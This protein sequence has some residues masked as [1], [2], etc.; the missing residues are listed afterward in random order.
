MI[1][2]KILMIA[3]A[4][5]V[6][7]GMAKAADAATSMTYTEDY[8]VI[9]SG[10]LLFVVS[11]E[12]NG[13]TSVTQGIGNLAI[14]HVAIAFRDSLN[15]NQLKVVEAIS[16]GVCVTPI[17]TFM[18]RA[19]PVGGN[20]P[21][22]VVGR[23]ACRD[24]VAVWISNALKYVGRPYDHLFMHDDQ[25]IYCSELVMLSY[26]NKNGKPIFAPIRMSFHD[27]SG[28]VTTF[29]RDYYARRGLRV[30]EGAQGSNPGQL[31]RDGNVRII[32][33]FF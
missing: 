20:R 2:T 24:N 19:T 17:D 16:R 33:R 9:E 15:D 7:C 27:K 1:K 23:L 13:I 21:L 32:Y 26:V 14:D 11:A 6:C 5:A 18:R 25:E 12:E 10:D 29:W 28:Q 4:F 30:P 31:S 8:G 3:I 22:V